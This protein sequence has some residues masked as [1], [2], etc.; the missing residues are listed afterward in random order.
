MTVVS[1]WRAPA[2]GPVGRQRDVDRFVHEDALIALDL[3]FLLAV[4]RPLVARAAAGGPD[5][6]SG[7]LAGRRAAR[8]FA[9]RECER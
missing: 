8:R 4:R 2:R 5:A 7:R 6:L 9:V 1:G 3:E